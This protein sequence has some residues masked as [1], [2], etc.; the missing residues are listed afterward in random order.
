MIQP[1][2]TKAFAFIDHHSRINRHVL[3]QSPSGDCFGCIPSL[4]WYKIR[5]LHLHLGIY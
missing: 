3:K 5:P 2:A 4:F 1:V